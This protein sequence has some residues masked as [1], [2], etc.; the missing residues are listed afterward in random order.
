MKEMMKIEIR[1]Q[2]KMWFQV[3]GKGMLPPL[4]W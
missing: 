3:V 4:G 1:I 2:M